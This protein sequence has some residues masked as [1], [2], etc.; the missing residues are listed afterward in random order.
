LQRLPGIN[1]KNSHSIARRVKTI[2][3]LCNKTFAE[4]RELLGSDSAAL[5]LHNLL[6]ESCRSEAPAADGKNS[7]AADQQQ[8]SRKGYRRKR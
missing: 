4:L 7:V 8:T 1:A 2:K 6:N 3:E 5:K